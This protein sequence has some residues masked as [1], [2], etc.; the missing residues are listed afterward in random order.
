[1]AGPGPADEPASDDS[2]PPCQ[3]ELAASRP[4]LL[5]M[6]CALGAG[7][8]L[9]GLPRRVC[10]HGKQ[11]PADALVA[12]GDPMRARRGPRRPIKGGD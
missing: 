12:K 7:V 10:Y 1:M 6:L 8:G 11:V 9:F 3:Q 4:P 5:S 2:V